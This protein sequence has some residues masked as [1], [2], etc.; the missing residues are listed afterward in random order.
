MNDQ[1]S[2]QT[3]R[4][5]TIRPCWDD[6]G[7]SCPKD[8]LRHLQAILEGW[9]NVRDYLDIPYTH[10]YLRDLAEREGREVPRWMYTRLGLRYIPQR[11]RV[12]LECSDRERQAS[13]RALL[14][15]TGLTRRELG[16][17]MADGMAMIVGGKECW[18]KV[19]VDQFGEDEW[20]ETGCGVAFDGMPYHEEYDFNFCPC[21]GKSIVFWKG[22]QG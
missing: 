10:T 21:C 8:A 5:S 17:K 9:R 6:L 22:E 12:G 3:P 1:T 4:I 7:I 2:P 14:D 11:F 13:L 18:V 15:S 20:W 16:D 19:R